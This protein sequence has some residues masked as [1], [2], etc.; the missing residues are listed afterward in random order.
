MAKSWLYSTSL[1]PDPEEL[2]NEIRSLLDMQLRQSAVREIP[3]TLDPGWDST[4]RYT[5]SSLRRTLSRRHFFRFSTVND[6]AVPRFHEE[7][8]AIK[9]R[10][11]DPRP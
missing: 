2:E 5:R 1:H 4:P 11:A 6:W 3:I 9:K 8:F 7:K 10:Q